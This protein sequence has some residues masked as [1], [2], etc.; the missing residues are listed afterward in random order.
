MANI[1][2]SGASTLPSKADILRFLEESDGKITKREIARAF[3]VKGADRVRLKTLLQEMEHAGQIE[4]DSSKSLRPAG[5]LPRVAVVEAVGVD[6]F[7]DLLLRPVNARPSA[8]VPPIRLVPGR[9]GS[10]AAPGRGDRLLVRLAPDPDE[11]GYRATI[12]KHLEK[13]ASKRLLGVFRGGPLGGRV[14]PVDK[15]SREALLIEEADVGTAKDGHLVVA[16]L[17]PRR[18]HRVHGLKPARIRETLGDVG[19]PGAISLIAIHEQGLPTEF[20][21]ECLREAEAARP[22]ALKD[23]EDLRHL[24]LI[25]ID[26]SDARDH[27]DAVYAEP[28][29]APDNAG[30]FRMLVAIADVA[31]YVTPGS[32]LD[33]DARERGNSAYFPDRVVPML[34][35]VLSTDLCSLKPGVDRP[36]MVAHIRIDA[37]GRKIAHRFSRALIRSHA[38]IAYE[39][40]EAAMS[41]KSAHD[42]P[43]EIIAH[44]LRPLH[45]AHD[46]LQKARDAREPL[47]IETEEKKIHLN[48]AG[49]VVAIEP[50]VTLRAH[51]VIEDMM[52]AANV[53]AAETLEAHGMACVYRVHDAP[54]RDRIESLREFL[55]TLD[56]RLSRGA[57]PSPHVFN[58]ILA[59]FAET[60][61]KSLIN[62]VVLRSQSQAVYSTENRGHFGLALARY[63]HFTSP[64]RRYADLLVHRGLI[65]A[66]SLGE[67]G[68]TES[69]IAGLEA[70]AEHISM[71][72]RRAMTAERDSVDRYLAHY[73]AGRVGEIFEGRIGGVAHFGLFVTLL[74][75]GGDGFVP[76]SSLGS[77]FYDHDE[78]RHALIGRRHGRVFRL[79]DMVEVRLIEAAPVSGGLKLEIV[80]EPARPARQMQPRKTKVKAAR[81]KPGRR[82]PRP[83]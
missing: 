16:E 15:R 49:E 79:G 20:S 39:A 33:R 55:K 14:E 52:I 44:V 4:R 26:P 64:I 53:C 71:T 28:D 42:V 31:H 23:R 17:L 69:E 59:H 60:P 76:I 36:A 81:P 24:P 50:R 48:A 22:V 32:A 41:G 38:N 21:P 66:L 1:S 56:Y 34:P 7:G 30:G 68:L 35:D 83:R 27:D 74:P 13:S 2:R 6:A 54:A 18:H 80:G 3:R 82:Q 77:D 19:A 12:V 10:M 57:E 11:G 75:S 25:T 70:T 73:L 45:D 65:S 5:Q 51:R 8:V 67:D 46:A 78:T 47:A 72:E 40:V 29:P 58:R 63:A 9:H 62:Q 37:E 43:E 61:Q